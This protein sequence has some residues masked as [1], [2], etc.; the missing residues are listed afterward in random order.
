MHDL[1]HSFLTAIFTFLNVNGII[2]LFDLKGVYVMNKQ[3]ATLYHQMQFDNYAYAVDVKEQAERRLKEVQ[4]VWKM[5]IIASL[6]GIFAPLASYILVRIFGTSAAIASAS[7]LSNICW[8]VSVVLSIICYTKTG[9]LSTA[10]R[11]SWNIAKVAWFIIPYFPID[12]ILGLDGLLISLYIL[13]F[14]PVF[15]MRHY[16]KQARKDLE[17]AENYLR[18]F[19]PVDNAYSAS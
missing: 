12:L 6:C 1:Q 11:W 14:F 4:A 7:F 10:F 2:F 8:I 3:K 16:K 15:V 13:F 5:S 17:D 18:Y 19:R 9:G